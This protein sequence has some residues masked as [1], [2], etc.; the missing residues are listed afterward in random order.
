MPFACVTARACK[1]ERALQ[2]LQQRVAR[3]DSVI[4]F[5]QLRSTT[6]SIATPRRAVQIPFTCADI[7]EMSSNYSVNRVLEVL[8][9]D[10][11]EYLPL[12]LVSLMW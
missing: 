9:W 3:K 2:G 11:A 5:H 1:L 8:H 4:G 10:T 7:Y 6:T 12:Q